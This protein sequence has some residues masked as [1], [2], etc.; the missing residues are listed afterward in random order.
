VSCNISIFEIT[1]GSDSLKFQNRHQRTSDS[2]CFRSIK[3]PPVL[4]SG[5]KILHQRTAGSVHFRSL[6]EL[7][8]FMKELVVRKV[9]FGFFRTKVL[10]KPSFVFRKNS[11]VYTR[12]VSGGN[13]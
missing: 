4:V 11:P 13:L 5:K 6:E 10:T 8:V 7:A 9:V 3:E 12:L 1:G 2:G